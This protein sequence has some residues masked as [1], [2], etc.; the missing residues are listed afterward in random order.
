MFDEYNDV[1]KVILSTT[2]KL[3]T[4]K[5]LQAT[6]MSLI[7]KESGVSTGNIYH[8]FKSK[9]EIINELFIGIVHECTKRV[10]N[11]PH[12]EKAVY[13]NFRQLWRSYINFCKDYPEAFMFYEQYSFSP[14]INSSVREKAAEMNIF[15]ALTDLYREAVHQGLLSS[16]F[17]PEIMV[18]MNYGS[19]VY[20]IKNSIEQCFVLTE[21]LIENIINSCWDTFSK[22]IM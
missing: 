22:E 17:T 14:Y 1:Q 15:R 16:C 3:I 2:L 11:T 12:V 4:K 18:T 20:V 13:D 6:S 19:I 10:L 9:E 21:E 5:E 8:Y 7:S